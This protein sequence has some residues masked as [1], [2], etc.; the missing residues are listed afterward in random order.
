MTRRTVWTLVMSLLCA[1]Y[2]VRASDSSPAL[3][4]LRMVTTAQWG[5][6]P[7]VLPESRRHTPT[8][9]TVHHAGVIWNDADDPAI[10]LRQLQ[11][12]GR[13]EKNWPDVPYHF[14]I[15]PDGRVF[16]GRDIHFEPESN[17][18]YPLAGTV[19]I[20]L[21]GD[22]ER[23]RVS[24]QQLIATAQLL[25]KLS[26][27]Y[28][29]DL[30]KLRTHLQAAPGQTSCPGRDF[31]RYVDNGSISRWASMIL[32]GQTP[33]ID[34]LPPLEIGPTTMIATTRATSQPE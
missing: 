14:L 7:G 4:S 24:R 5:S 8:T 3:P 10:K 6:Q 16:Q 13:R 26:T 22:F 31:Q 1:G 12:W 25:A 20:Q 29:L 32:A 33:T 9:L 19:N 17:T 30:E 27:D 23:Q 18:K 21:W 2:I 11:S 28:G 34:L 15:A